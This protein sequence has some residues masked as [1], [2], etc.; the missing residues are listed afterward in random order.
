MGCSSSV[1][2]ELVPRLPT[3]SISRII[4]LLTPPG[5]DVTK[6]I[7]GFSGAF[8]YKFVSVGKLVRDEIN[9]NT[10]YSQVIVDNLEKYRYINDAIL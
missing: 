9:K 4:V 10:Q 5:F 3:S 1:Q 6:F 7:K 8:D 2:E